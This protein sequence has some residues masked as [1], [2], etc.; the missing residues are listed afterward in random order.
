M[1]PINI[2]S[3]IIFLM[4]PVFCLG[5][6]YAV[7]EEVKELNNQND[8]DTYEMNLNDVVIGNRGELN[9]LVWPT[10]VL[11]GD[12]DN[13]GLKEGVC[14]W[15]DSRDNKGMCLIAEFVKDDSKCRG[16]DEIILC[17]IDDINTRDQ[18]LKVVTHDFDSDGIM[19]YIIFVI[20][21]IDYATQFFVI[22][23]NG[24]GI[25]PCESGL[26]NFF[27]LVGSGAAFEPYIHNDTIYGR[28]AFRGYSYNEWIY[29]NGKL[30]KLSD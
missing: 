10:P 14:F 19:E 6:T 26:K 5:N 30:R 24:H 18:T 28:K 13:D 20:D 12:S 22:R 15:L 16:G 25:S 11:Y 23:T 3:I 29:R 21:N 17:P 1:K 27:E 9:S 8:L 4:F 7:T 2:I